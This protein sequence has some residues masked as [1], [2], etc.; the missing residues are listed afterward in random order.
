MHQ[1]V[2]KLDGWQRCDAGELAGEARGYLA[3]S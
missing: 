1:Q 3:W 2:N